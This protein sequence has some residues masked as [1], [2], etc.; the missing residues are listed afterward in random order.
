MKKNP[1]TKIFSN[2]ISKTK[3]GNKIGTAPAAK[4][5][6]SFNKSSFCEIYGKLKLPF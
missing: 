3:G 1:V 6:R 2:E 4:K 5:E